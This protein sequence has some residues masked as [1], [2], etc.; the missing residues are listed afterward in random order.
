MKL[1]FSDQ[2]KQL[3]AKTIEYE[4]ISSVNLMERAACACYDIIINRYKDSSSFTIIAGTGNNGGD[5][6]VIARKLAE[7]GKRVKVFVVKYS[8]NLSDDS[9][10][11]YEKLKKLN[12]YIKELTSTDKELIIDKNSIVIDGIFGSGLS[13]AVTGWL[14]DIINSINTSD[15]AIVSI[16]IPSGLFGE[17]NRLVYDNKDAKVVEADLV[18]AL[19]QPSLSLMFPENYM[20]VKEFVIVPIGLSNIAKSEIVTDYYMLTE[21]NIGTLLKERLPYSHKGVFGNVLVVAGK[22]GMM[23]AATLCAKSA[24]RTG[25]GL[26]TL[27]VPSK[28]V[29]IAQIA[30]PEAIMSVDESDYIYTGV[31]DTDHFSAIVVGPGLGCKPNTRKGL[32]ELLKSD[33]KMI[34][35][36]D[37]LNILSEEDD[38]EKLIPESSILTPHPK[39]F[40]RLFGKFADSYSRIIYLKRWCNEKSVTVVIK[41]AHTTII[42]NAGDVYINSTGNSGMASGGSGDVLSGIIVSLLGQGYSVSEASRIGVYLHGLS[43]DMA[44]E[45]QS[46]ESLIATDII[47]N[48]GSAFNYIRDNRD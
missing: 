4:P 15:A 39:E 5:A 41:G 9:F 20:F 44:L 28:C 7:A 47:E 32:L 38:W 43:A 42:D 2:I 46:E 6:F 23:G 30:V 19:E 37:A 18:L 11:N 16:D 22:Y 35:D 8:D 24:Y 34:I 40:E 29:D 45:K 3:D 36:A 27:H 13:R 10:V 26:V 14:A 1:F 21:Q 48:I 12:V 33:K 25:S 17:D 31:S